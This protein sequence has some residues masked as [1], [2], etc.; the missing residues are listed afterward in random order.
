MSS[1]TIRP[2]EVAEWP[3]LR[4]L[5][6]R[7]LEDTPGAFSATYDEA[8]RRSETEWRAML[9]DPTRRVF[10]LFDGDTMIGI[11]GVL[12]SREDSSGQTAVLVMSY[13]VR[14]YRG[15]GLSRMLYEARL[16]WARAHP[17]LNR[18]VVSHRESNEASRRANQRHGFVPTGQISPRVWPDGVTEGEVFYELQL[19]KPVR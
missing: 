2:L 17:K 1:I 6:L 18:I 11:T 3:Q 7:A 8:V 15:R 14:E 19:S 12:T 16:A 9:T 4:D 13:I 10:G 5:R